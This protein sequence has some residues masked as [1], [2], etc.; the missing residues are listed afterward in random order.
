MGTPQTLLTRF[1]H[2]RNLLVAGTLAL[3]FSLTLAIFVEANYARPHCAAWAASRQ[4]TYAGLEYPSAPPGMPGR[5]V[6]TCLLL[7]SRRALVTIPFAD[8]APHR[9]SAALVDLATTP[10]LTMPLLLLVFVAGLFR[11][12]G[13]LGIRR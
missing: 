6:A 13:A 1:E 4:L 10:L 12:Y 2:V 7:D 5:R 11:V 9:A 3:G 8:V